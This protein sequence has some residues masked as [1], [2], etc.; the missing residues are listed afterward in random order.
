VESEWR[1]TGW[2]AGGVNEKEWAESFSDAKELEL[3]KRGALSKRATLPS[4]IDNTTHPAFRP[5]FNQK[6]GSCAQASGVGY[7]FTYEINCIRGLP[8]NTLENQ[9]PYDFTYNFL[10][11]GSGDNGTNTNTGWDI[12]KAIG[13]PNARDYGGFGLGKFK[14]WVS[15]YDVYYNGMYNRLKEYFYIFIRKPEDIEKMKQ[16]LVDRANGSPEGGCLVFSANATGEQLVKL[17]SG[18][19]EAGKTALVKFGTSGGHSMTIAGYN[20]QVCYDYNNDGKY[21]NDIDLNGDNKLDVRDWEIGAALLVN[22]WGSSWGNNGKAWI[23][24]K[25]LADTSTNGG[26]YYNSLTG[27]KLYEDTIIKPNLTFKFSLAHPNRSSIRIRAGYS[28]NLQATSPSTSKSFASAFSFSG[29]AFP[30]QGETNE[31]IE[32]GL[33]I[34]DLLVKIGDRA[35]SFFLQ[36]ESKSG[37]GTISNFSLIDYTNDQ[38]IEYPYHKSQEDFSNGI[39]YF[40]IIKPAVSIK[41][42]SPNGQEK[43]ERGNTYQIRWNTTIEDNVK[44]EL[45][46]NGTVFSTLEKSLPNSGAY[47]WDIPEDLE[48]DT[49]YQICISS[50]NDTNSRDKSD[51]PFSIQRNS[52]LLL[53]SPDHQQMLLTGSSVVISWKDDFN[54]DVKIEIY[55]NGVYTQTITDT[56]SGSNSYQWVIPDSFASGFD[57]RIR[58]ISITN[59]ERFDESDSNLIIMHQP[60]TAPYVQDFDAFKEG[61]KVIDS[62]EQIV[63]DDIDWTVIK[64]P[65]PFRKTHQGGTGAHS[66]HSGKDGNYI[67]VHSSSPN[68]PGKTATLLSPLID[69]RNS[70]IKNCVFWVHMFS[71]ESKMGKLVV[72]V[73]ANGIWIDS[74]LCISGNQGDNWI[75]QILDLSAFN[76]DF[77]QIRFRALTGTGDESDICIDDFMAGTEITSTLVSRHLVPSVR[78]FFRDKFLQFQNYEGFARIISLDGTVLSSVNKVRHNYTM[79]ISG[80]RSGTYLLMIDK[81]VMRFV[82]SGR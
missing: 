61:N 43:W 18:T 58:V 39:T 8:S 17:A 60:R 72:D 76:S 16:W 44:I 22:S 28:T 29:G 10:N 26:I 50:V 24:Y 80:L 27:I 57:Y 69:F 12:I 23:M 49:S 54:D 64:G 7:V 68:N 51:L 31:P 34:S 55:R 20:D 42:V 79:D 40:K 46:R 73:N 71:S 45:L 81:K 30:M 5:I 3:P 59:E 62:W 36:I 38:H 21:T 75:Q 6:G 66:D 13:V 67:Y 2:I 82:K 78:V 1:L 37:S 11:S 9:Y 56:V 48:L 74:V 4:S 14:E 47:Q 52:A 53:T 77:F 70:S 33:D 15:G 65:T 25:V 32:I 19:P 63:T 41:V 35:A